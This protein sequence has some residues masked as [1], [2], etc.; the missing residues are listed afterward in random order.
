MADFPALPL[1]TDALLGDTLHLSAEEFGAYL[2]LLIVSWRTP[3]CTLPDDDDDLARY[4]RVSKRRWQQR[5]RPRLEPFFTINAQTWKQK[6]LLAERDFVARNAAQKS[7][8][9]TA[10]ALKRKETA[11]TAVTEPLQRLGQRKANRT[12]TPTPTPTPISKNPESNDSGVISLN[13][14]IPKL[15]QDAWNSF[16]DT[17]GLPQCQ[18]MTKARASAARARW[19]DAGGAEGI[20]AAFDKIR[21]L[22]WMHGENKRGWRANFDFLLQ[23]SSFTKLMEGAYDGGNHERDW[24]SIMRTE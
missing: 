13:G 11:S 21:R 24:R 18:K 1:W 12:A 15:M 4:C 10:S 20:Q 8:A 19:K 9:G 2:L 3:T 6:R 17:L 23:E 7:K 14:E 16:A 5:L 22:R